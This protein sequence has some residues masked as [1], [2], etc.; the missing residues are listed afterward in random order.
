[1]VPLDMEPS[2]PDPF[3]IDPP[4]WPE[5]LDM[6]PPDWPEPLDMEPLDWPE[7][8]DME[9]LDWPEPP[10]EPDPRLPVCAPAA[11]AMAAQATDMARMVM[12]FMMFLSLIRDATHL[13]FKASSP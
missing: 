7:P 2:E 8:L 11:V 4:D 3:D 5:P 6:E 9:P 12:R 10:I 1:M 13:P